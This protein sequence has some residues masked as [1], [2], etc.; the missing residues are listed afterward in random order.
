MLCQALRLKQ[1]FP[2]SLNANGLSATTS[3][4]E[5]FVGIANAH[6]HT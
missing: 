6:L 4:L 3:S 2:A 5:S 1:A